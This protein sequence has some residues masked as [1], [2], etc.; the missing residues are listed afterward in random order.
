MALKSMTGFG[1]GTAKAGDVQIDVELSSVNR[2]QLDVSLR[3]PS[4]L[5][6]FEAQTQ[7]VVK[8]TVSR[9]RITGS[10]QLESAGGPGDVSLDLKKAESAVKQLRAAAKKL[11]LDDTL[12]ANALLRIP[13]LF[14]SA[15]ADVE[16]EE[17]SQP[18]EKALRAALKKLEAMRVTEGRALEADFRARLKILE[19]ILT[20]IRRLAPLVVSKGRKKLFQ[21][22]ES[23]FAEAS[24]DKKDF[25]KDERIIREI[26]LFGEKAD[27]SEEI[28]RLKSHIQQFR[29]MMRSPE[30]AGRPLDFLAQEFF[31]EINTIGSK[32]NDLQITQ[33]VV[34]FKTELERIREQIQN[35]E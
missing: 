7:K 21:G 2:K 27:I 28:T 22:L 14:Q 31:R 10:V 1:A 19:S 35:V 32:A 17:I 15:T 20:E 6:G 25:S 30:P 12:D 4:A 16:L 23:A 18:L 33:Q 3:L 8:E 5:A 13:N 26:A 29:K 24:A 9:G 11:K 34:A